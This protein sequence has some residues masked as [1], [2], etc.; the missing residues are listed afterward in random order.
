MKSLLLFLLC[1]LPVQLFAE[2]DAKSSE[3]RVLSYNVWYG[4][5]KQTDRKKKLLEYVGSLK[6]DVV[7][8][9]ELNSYTEEKLAQDARA[10]GHPYSALL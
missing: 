7:S 3:L 10:W 1:L 6:P 4:F 8:L 2:S 5:T 9:Q